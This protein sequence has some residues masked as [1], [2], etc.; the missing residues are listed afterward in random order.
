MKNQIIFCVSLNHVSTCTIALKPL[1]ISSWMTEPSSTSLWNG[2]ELKI[3]PLTTFYQGP[4]QHNNHLGCLWGPEASC[5]SLSPA[6]SYH[7]LQPHKPFIIPC[8]AAQLDS[9]HQGCGYT[10]NLC[11]CQ[12]WAGPSGRGTGQAFDSF[13]PAGNARRGLCGNT[14]WPQP[15]SEPSIYWRGVPK[16]LTSLSL[17]FIPSPASLIPFKW[18]AGT[19]LLLHYTC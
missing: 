17:P 4:H 12:W 19:F 1:L 9:S 11:T 18:G 7:L 16:V 14:V 10:K 15:M 3:M 6:F 5:S 2:E 8:S 13:P